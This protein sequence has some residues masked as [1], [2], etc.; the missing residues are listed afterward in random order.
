[1]LPKVELPIFD[2][3]PKDFQIFMSTFEEIV[4]S[5]TSDGNMRLT[6][7]LQYTTGNAKASIAA[8]ALI[9]GREGY[10]KAKQT[11]LER[12]GHPLLVTHHIVSD[13][14][15]G[16]R[17]N[18]TSELQQ[19]ADDVNL[20]DVTL[21]KL[22]THCEIDTQQCI[23]D[24]TKRCPESLQAKWRHR[25][26]KF[27]DANARYPKFDEFVKFI[28]KEARDANDP[29]Y[30][31]DISKTVKTTVNNVVVGKP[32]VKFSEP[33]SPNVATVTSNVKVSESQGSKVSATPCVVCKGDNHRLFY[34]EKFKSLSPPERLQIVRDNKLCF[35]CLW[36]GHGSAT[37]RKQSVCS[38]PGCGRKHTKFI[39]VEAPSDDKPQVG[40]RLVENGS[41][42][43]RSRVYLPIVEIKVNDEIVHALLDTGSTNTFVVESLV[44]KLS[45]EGK[46]LSYKLNTLGLCSDVKSQVVSC[47]VQSPVDGKKYDVEAIVVQ[48]VPVTYPG[49]GVDISV[50]PHLAGTVKA[51]PNEVKVELLIGMDNA[52]LLRPLEVKSGQNNEPYAVR[53]VLGW[54]LNGP[55]MCEAEG[56]VS[57]LHVNITNSPHSSWC[58]RS[59]TKTSLLCR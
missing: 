25:A 36:A 27:K 1:M 10:E 43:A 40:A 6:R 46:D 39:H 48:N 34:C 30:G 13:L 57:S 31:N 5:N 15:G 59:S 41:I 49:S 29:V 55:V 33:H 8:C 45:L 14:K 21:H 16:K 32:N 19:L 7:L 42:S 24:I 54:S 20:A 52:H 23:I 56:E 26:L 9:G 58:M 51:I 12:F 50:F 44:H 22:G 35:N 11:L 37:C 17:I 4:E 3:K 53:T 2:G 18:K 47:T 28:T 38:V